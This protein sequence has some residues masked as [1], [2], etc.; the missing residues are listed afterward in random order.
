M[1]QSDELT[2]PYYLDE[3]QSAPLTD[4]FTD[5]RHD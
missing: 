3:D 5:Q 2:P 4:H 1:P